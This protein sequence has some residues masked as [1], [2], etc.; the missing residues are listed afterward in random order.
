M[1]NNISN[2]LSKFKTLFHVRMKEILDSALRRA[3][4]TVAEE[5]MFLVNN[6]HNQDKKLVDPA[7][8]VVVEFIN[9]LERELHHAADEVLK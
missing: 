9:D 5:A 7:M 3:C 8:I 6:Y 2:E 4:C 1:K